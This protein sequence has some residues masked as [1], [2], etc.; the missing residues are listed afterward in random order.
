MI[1]VNVHT[2]RAGLRNDIPLESISDILPRDDSVLWI[3]VVEPTDDEIRLLAEEFGFHPLAL[4]DAQRRHQ[5][6]K[7]DHY[8]GFLFLVF[9]GLES[10]DGRPTTRE[11]GIFAGKNYL[12]TVHDGT[13]GA[14]P[15]TAERWCRNVETLGNRGVGLL[16]YSLLDTLVDGYFPCVDEMAERVEELEVAIFERTDTGAQAEIFALKKDLLAIRRVL[17][18]E[19]DV[20]NA[21]VRRDA[22]VFGEGVVVYFQDV[23]DHI[24]RVTDS[25]DTYRDLLSSALDAHLS[26][27]SFHL[28]EVVR[29]LTSSSI[30]LMSVTLIAGIYGMN[31]AYMPELDWT[32]GYAWAL[33]LMAAVA[34]S[35]ALL[36]KRIDWL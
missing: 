3:D 13:L 21:L 23:Y 2:D 26:M 11:V 14:I 9:Y 30:I 32:Y 12:V 29:R 10:V 34:V 35:L 28:N 19:R 36:F 8:D 22:P 25:V 1:R 16:V 31:F 7:I 27:T 5:R 15:E 6:P 4:E 18:P 17:G 24:L 33:G 20:M